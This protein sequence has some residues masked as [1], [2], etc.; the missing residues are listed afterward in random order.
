MVLKLLEGEVPQQ[1]MIVNFEPIGCHETMHRFWEMFFL[2]QKVKH[3]SPGACVVHWFTAV[4]LPSTS[5]FM[6]Q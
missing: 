4:E 6:F 1:Q 5:M 2:Y 3:R